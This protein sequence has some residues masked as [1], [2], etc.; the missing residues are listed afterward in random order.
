MAIINPGD[1]IIDEDVVDGTELARRLER[2]YASFHS[3]NSSTTRP[4]ELTAG[5][6]WA[7]SVTGGFEV[8]LFDG[9]QDVKISSAINGTGELG[10]QGPPGPPGPSAVSTDPE[11]MAYLGSDNLIYVPLVES[12]G[13]GGEV[14]EPTQP[15]SVLGW[16]GEN[17]VWA[18]AGELSWTTT[19]GSLGSFYTGSPISN[20]QLAAVSSVSPANIKYRVSTGE[21]PQGLSLSSSGL[22]T[23]TPVNGAITQ[24]FTVEAIAVACPPIFLDVSIKITQTVVTWVTAAGELTTA[25]LNEQYEQFQLQATSNSGTKVTFAITQGVLPTGL[26]MNADGL[27]TG[28]TT[29]EQTEIF[30]VTATA[31]MVSEDRQFSIESVEKA[32]AGSQEFT[33]SGPFTVPKGHK[34]L[35]VTMVGA[36]GGGGA[37][38]SSGTIYASGSGGSGGFYQEFVIPVT[39]GE[40]LSVM[41]GAGGYGGNYRFNGVYNYAPNNPGDFNGGAGGNSSINRGETPIVLA[42]GGGGGG[43]VGGG[44]AGGSPSGVAGGGGG[45]P[46]GACSQGTYG[47]VNAL[48]IGSGGSTPDVCTIGGAGQNGIVQIR[49]E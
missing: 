32:P 26:T 8:Y 4:F 1:N 24:N 11:N 17:Y 7:K 40:A 31:D 15:G 28:T 20:I 27:I 5:G 3:Q 39:G 29:V 2:F 49:W 22:I 19:T 34:S 37:N 6:L 13:L 44:G 46:C 42:G 48:S 23:G 33:T 9:T 21:L 16:D 25:I 14:P 38:N 12:G 45:Y 41:V 47:G 43:S 30:T 36:G 35:I 10:E 18:L